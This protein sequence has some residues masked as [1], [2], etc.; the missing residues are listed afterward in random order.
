VSEILKV[1]REEFGKETYST[2]FLTEIDDDSS[3]WDERGVRVERVGE[4]WKGDESK[5]F[6]ELFTAIATLGA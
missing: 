6:V 1:V 2:T 3:S 4:G 5:G